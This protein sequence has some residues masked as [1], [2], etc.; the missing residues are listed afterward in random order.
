MPA[1]LKGTLCF[2]GKET[3]VNERLIINRKIK[4]AL[5]ATISASSDFHLFSS[6]RIVRLQMTGVRWG[7][8]RPWRETWRRK[9]CPTQW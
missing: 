1:I 5:I 7:K 3:R 6:C 4:S 9:S 8:K 2:A